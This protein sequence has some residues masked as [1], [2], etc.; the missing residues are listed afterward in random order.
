[1]ATSAERNLGKYY[2]KMGGGG[3]LE[4]LQKTRRGEE[5]CTNCNNNNFNSFL[6]Q[7][8]FLMF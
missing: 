8:A 2:M 7:A 5:L 3:I 1:M 6:D 4:K